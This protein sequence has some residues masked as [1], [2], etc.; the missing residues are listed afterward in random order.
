[1]A[2]GTLAN[3]AKGGRPSARRAE[4]WIEGR[5]SA[6]EPPPTP[7]PASEPQPEPAPAQGPIRTKIT[8]TLPEDLIEKV[9]I[10]AIREKKRFNQVI[11]ERLAQSFERE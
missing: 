3:A 10:Q 7:E 8:T 6:T 9:K 2:R 11:E 1:V 4:D 5:E